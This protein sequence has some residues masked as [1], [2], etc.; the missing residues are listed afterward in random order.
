M[1]SCSIIALMLLPIFTHSISKNNEPLEA[2]YPLYDTIPYSDP[3]EIQTKGGL[4]TQTK[5]KEQICKRAHVYDKIYDAQQLVPSSIQI[6]HDTAA[7]SNP[8]TVI[9]NVPKDGNQMLEDDDKL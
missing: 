3:A 6:D 1:P 5:E 7:D 2:I 9:E 4:T 8:K